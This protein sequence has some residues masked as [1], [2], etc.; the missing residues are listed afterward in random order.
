MYLSGDNKYK[1]GRVV[2]P[3]QRISDIIPKSLLNFEVWEGG[4][5]SFLD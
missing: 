1:G 3:Y 2:L 5:F 4:S